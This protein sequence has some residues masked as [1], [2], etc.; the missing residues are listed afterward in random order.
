MQTDLGKMSEAYFP[1]GRVLLISEAGDMTVERWVHCDGCDKPT[2]K[3]MLFNQI[4]DR[5]V[6]WW[7]CPM[8]STSK[9]H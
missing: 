8:C 2:P 4:V 5:E 7:L 1:D 6:V 3:S 9:S